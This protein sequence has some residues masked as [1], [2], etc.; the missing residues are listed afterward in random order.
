[1][2]AINNSDELCCARAIVTMRAWCHRDE[3]VM[4]KANYN[5]MRK[6]RPLQGIKAKELH[7]MSGVA[8]GPCGLD[9]LELFQKALSPDYQLLVMCRMRPFFLLYKGP[10]APHQICLLKSNSH[11][12]GCTSFS[13]FVNRSY[14][15]LECE[16]GYDVDDAKHHSCRGRKCRSCGRV[17]CPEYKFGTQP[18]TLCTRCNRE[19]WPIVCNIIART[20]RAMNASVAPN[21]APST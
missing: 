2:I 19:F 15:C 14:W 1:V 21:V 8:E 5:N 20:R 16:K 3:G 6:G 7:T 13:G 10:P 17:T 11:Y 12:D 9:E 4:G 18:N